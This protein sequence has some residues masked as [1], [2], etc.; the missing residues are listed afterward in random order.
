MPLAIFLAEFQLPG[1]HMLVS[2]N[3][4]IVIATT[5]TQPSRPTACQFGNAS[6]FNAYLYD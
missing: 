4:V 6:V 1:C 2:Q 5:N 3:E